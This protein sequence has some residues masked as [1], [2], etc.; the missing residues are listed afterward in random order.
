MAP[1]WPGRL[2]F[3]GQYNGSPTYIRVNRGWEVN[4]RQD[5]G[6]ADSGDKTHEFWGYKKKATGHL[7][8][9]PRKQNRLHFL[10]S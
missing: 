7:Y 1:C 8:P 2:S 9:S 6:L 4:K 5:T 3:V 10:H